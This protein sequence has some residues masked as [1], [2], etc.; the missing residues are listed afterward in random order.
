[1]SKV[2][3]RNPATIFGCSVKQ[4]PKDQL[5]PAA[6][7]AREI[8][9]ANHPTTT[10]LPLAALTKES[11]DLFQSIMESPLRIAVLTSKFWGPQG[12]NLTVGFLEPTTR[13]LADKII[14]YMNKWGSRANATFLY[15]EDAANAQVRISRGAGGYWSYLGTDILHIAKGEPTMN[16]EGF[17]LKT[18]ASEYDRVVCHE[19]GH[20]LGF[21]HEHMRKDLVALLDPQKTIEYFRR[22]QGW[23]TQEI[24]QQVLK[25][26][27]ERTLIGTPVDQ[28]SIMCY[29]LPGEITKNGKPI[30]GGLVINESDYAFA[31][32]IYPKPN[33]PSAPPPTP[34]KVRYLIESD[35]EITVTKQ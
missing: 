22:T 3:K 1:M 31:S 17:I 5:I 8:N 19:T 35:S 27:D 4:L 25:S 30:R 12:V 7:L 16:L 11:K 20:T 21:P 29:Q 28:D 26:L 34:G 6:A 18:S 24:E 10:A 9:P 14:S 23:S 13:L 15:T 32:K 2:S 33:T